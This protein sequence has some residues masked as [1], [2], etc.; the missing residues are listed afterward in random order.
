MLA[1][2]FEA[3][4]PREGKYMLLKGDAKDYKTVTLV[5]ASSLEQYVVTDCLAIAAKQ[6]NKQTTLKSSRS[7]DQPCGGLLVS[8]AAGS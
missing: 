1:H 6:E 4:T 7:S 2:T 5:K 3:N 8:C